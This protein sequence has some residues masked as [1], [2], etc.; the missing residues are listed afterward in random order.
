M[1]GTDSLLANNV[2]LQRILL[3]RLDKGRTMEGMVMEDQSS[4]TTH[5]HPSEAPPPPL[6]PVRP[7]IFK[8]RL[9]VNCNRNSLD[10]PSLPFVSFPNTAEEELTTLREK[11][12]MLEK[13]N[14]RMKEEMRR[15]CSLSVAAAI[16]SDVTTDL[17]D[18]GGG[19]GDEL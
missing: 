6:H 5:R 13:E 16:A 7:D 11:V 14:K 18:G 15:L 19:G 9:T 1:H 2:P 10:D 17:D 3:G 8:N 4:T 12:E